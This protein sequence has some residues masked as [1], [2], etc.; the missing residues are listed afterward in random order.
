VSRGPISDPGMVQSLK[1][2]LDRAYKL[3]RY[4]DVVKPQPMWYMARGREDSTPVVLE[5]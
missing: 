2:L 3:K 5:P 1:E 4:S